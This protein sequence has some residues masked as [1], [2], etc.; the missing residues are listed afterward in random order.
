M[1][2]ILPSANANTNAAGVPAGINN[3]NKY[4]QHFADNLQSGHPGGVM[5]AFC[6]GHVIFLRGDIADSTN[7]PYKQIYD[8]PYYQLVNPIDK[9]GPSSVMLDESLYSQP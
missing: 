5:A 9:A 1:H 8:T 7:G 4:P 6:D 2:Q 3:T